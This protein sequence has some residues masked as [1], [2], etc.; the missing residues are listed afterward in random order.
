MSKFIAVLCLACL[1]PTAQAADLLGI[2]AMLGDTDRSPV[3]HGWTVG[4]VAYSGTSPYKDGPA[5]TMPIPGGIYIGKDFMFLGDRAFYTFARQGGLQYY[6]RVRLRLGNL[7]P[8]DN[9]QWAGLDKRKG[10]LEAGLGVGW[11]SDVGL[12][13]ARTSSDISGRS[14]GTELLF[15]W[16][17]P[18]V[19]ENWM[20]MPGLGAMWRQDKLANYYFGGISAAE[21]AP[22]R[23][24]YDVGHAWSFV[25]SVVASYR[26]NAQWLIGGVLSADVFSDT[27]KNSPL[28]QQRARYDVLLGL[29]YVWR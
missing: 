4:G 29:G 15:N 17:A 27:I 2:E 22:G 8:K 3:P 7:D 16:S 24:A 14:K 1:M 5:T 11:I 12:W 18:L 6:G 25:P 9:P 26:I 13:T 19:R 21:A 28:V 10:Q 20:V 23:P